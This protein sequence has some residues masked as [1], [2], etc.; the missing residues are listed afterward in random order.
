MIR[1]EGLE[2]RV[3]DLAD[4][5]AFHFNQPSRTAYRSMDNDIGLVGET[6]LVELTD[7]LII[8]N[9]TQID[10]HVGYIFISALRF[11]KKGLYVFPHALGLLDDVLGIFD[12]TLVVDAGSA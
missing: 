9:V 4:G 1:S 3:V 11:G 6:L 12:F 2:L 10:N 8:G 7:N 5:H